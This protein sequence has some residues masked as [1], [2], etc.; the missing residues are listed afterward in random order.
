M[1]IISK[2]GCPI[3]RWELDDVEFGITIRKNGDCTVLSEDIL[4]EEY[5]KASRDFGIFSMAN[6][7]LVVE[8]AVCGS[9][10]GGEK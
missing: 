8:D 5:V 4:S 2:E 6:G 3:E 1:D 10:E 9:G 7:G